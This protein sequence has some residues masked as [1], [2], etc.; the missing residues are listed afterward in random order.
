MV[1]VPG[2]KKET[3]SGY[4]D[5]WYNLTGFQYGP[6]VYMIYILHDIPGLVYT[7]TTKPFPSIE[8]PNEVF[9]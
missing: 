5:W 7:N 6:Q 9:S 8:N 3:Q 1:W 2:R 4:P